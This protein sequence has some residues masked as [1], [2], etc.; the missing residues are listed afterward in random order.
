[1]VGDPQKGEGG[2]VIRP[3]PAEGVGSLGPAGGGTDDI[4]KGAFQYR[5]NQASARAVGDPG[6]ALLGREEN[7]GDEQPGRRVSGGVARLGRIVLRVLHVCPANH[8]E[9]GWLGGRGRKAGA[10]GFAQRRVPTLA[11]APM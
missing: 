5:P 8:D 6:T 3:E 10:K 7:V 4:E 11:A 9:A 2:V 1:V